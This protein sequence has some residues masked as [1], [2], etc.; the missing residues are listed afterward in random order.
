MNV[1]RSGRKFSQVIYINFYAGD[2]A[3]IIFAQMAV[4]SLAVI[5]S[6]FALLVSSPS[7]TFNPYGFQ[8]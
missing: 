8:R 3:Y 2:I 4:L 6:R 1:L 7:I 5:G